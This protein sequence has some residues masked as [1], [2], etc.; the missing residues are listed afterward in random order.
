MRSRVLLL[1]LLLFAVLGL[2][3]TPALAQDEEQSV[4]V[5]LTTTD[6][7]GDKVPIVGVS[8]EVSLDGAL[9]G[10]GVSNEEGVFNLPVE[11]IGEYTLAIDPNTLPEGVALRDPSV[12][13]RTAKVE[14]GAGHRSSHFRSR[15]RR[16]HRLPS[17]HR[18]GRNTSGAAC[19]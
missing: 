8:F 11:G 15:D 7:N 6:S 17:E 16:R 12:T 3:A 1:G 18:N 5:K 19:A 2:S 10:E 4:E 14:V 13:E 9:I